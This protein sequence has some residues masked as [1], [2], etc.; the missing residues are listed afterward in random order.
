MQARTLTVQQRDDGVAVVSL[1]RPDRHN[2]FDDALIAELTEAF[3]AIDDDAKVRAVLLRG[4]GK[5]FSAGADIAWMREQGA[6]DEATNLAGAQRMER[7][8]RAIHDCKK[9][10]LARV[11][12]AALGG[13]TGLTAAADIAIAAESTVFGFTEVRLGILPAVISPYVIEK[14]GLAKAKALFL[15]GSRF[16]AREAERIGLVFK[17]VP[18]ASLDAEIEK[19]LG[20]L[21]K[22]GPKA[23]AGVKDLLASV[24][25]RAVADEAVVA[26]TTRAIASIRGSS[27]A[28]EGLAAFLD[29]RAPAWTEQRS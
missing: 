14:V 24:G 17:A 21:M 20:E 18:D 10:V 16:D 26:T 22:G 8:F 13:G 7:A 28:R 9:P 25:A 29:K 23:L 2:A 6:S 15:L 27:E 12:G 19:A 1:A 3:R 4:E 5:S 11:H